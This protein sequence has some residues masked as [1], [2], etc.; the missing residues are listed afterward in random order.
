[1]T[2]R[3]HWLEDYSGDETEY[4]SVSVISSYSPTGSEEIT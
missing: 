1:M 4:S 2:Y 3:G